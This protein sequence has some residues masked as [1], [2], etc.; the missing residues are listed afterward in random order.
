ML[1]KRS[2]FPFLIRWAVPADWEEMMKMVWETFLKF[3]GNDYTEEGIR[4]FRDFITDEGLYEF[5]LRGNYQVMVALD[6]NRVIGMASVRNQNHLSL[7]FVDEAYQR[8]GVGRMLIKK[9]C[10]HLQEQGERYMSVKA[11][12]YA[13]LFY[14]KQGFRAVRPEEEYSGIRVTPM[15]KFF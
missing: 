3:E 9:M 15:E 1:S 4:N 12:P 7:L 10:V 2:T 14:K 11:S 5:F 6:G 13:L 8:K